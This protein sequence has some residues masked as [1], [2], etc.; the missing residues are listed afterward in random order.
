MKWGRGVTQAEMR[1]QK[2]RDELHEMA[3]PLTRTKDD[4]DY[5]QHLKGQ[6]H[7]EDPMR[8]FLLSQRENTAAAAGVQSPLPDNSTC[9]VHLAPL[10]FPC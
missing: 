8:A 3:K 9:S 2:I 4:V 5:N 6:L 1:E 7:A 10:L